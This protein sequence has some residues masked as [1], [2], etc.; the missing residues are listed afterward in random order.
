MRPAPQREGESD[1]AFRD[2]VEEGDRKWREMQSSI[3]T[4]P[5]RDLNGGRRGGGRGGS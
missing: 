3:I 4:R 1:Q 2:R 5:T